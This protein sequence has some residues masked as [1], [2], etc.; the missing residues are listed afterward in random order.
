MGWITVIWS[1]TSGACVMLA[2][3][4]LLVWFRDRRSWASLCFSLTV[5]GVLG[6]A[7]SEV[8]TMHTD[9]PDVFGHVFRWTHLVYA[10]GVI[11][12]LGFVHFYFG[13]GRKW[14]L[15]LA[16]GLRVLV[17]IP[18]FTTGLNLHIDRLMNSMH[19]EDREPAS[20]AV[21]NSFN[22]DGNSRE[23]LIGQTAE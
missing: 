15:A 8:I 12:S 20:H 11:G 16:I 5:V 21:A 22:G 19:P 23:E 14:L 1:A 7:I 10:V 3:M 6:L 17:Q 13:T 9:S 18:N 2:L 4:H